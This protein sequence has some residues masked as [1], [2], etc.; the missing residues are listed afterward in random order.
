MYFSLLFKF[1]WNV[2]FWWN[3]FL[4]LICMDEL[5]TL[6]EREEGLQNADMVGVL[7]NNAIVVTRETTTDK[8]DLPLA[9][10]DLFRRADNLE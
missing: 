3:V 8:Y 9:W 1:D 2:L 10:V 4:G 7:S 5:T 6:A